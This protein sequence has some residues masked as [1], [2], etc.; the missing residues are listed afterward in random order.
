MGL[1]LEPMRELTNNHCFKK[2][3]IFRNLSLFGSYKAANAC[4]PP[5]CTKAPIGFPADISLFQTF[6]SNKKEAHFIFLYILKPQLV[7][8]RIAAARNRTEDNLTIHYFYLMN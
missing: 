7:T 5:K 1:V 8:E 2:D 6:C 3:L 4:H